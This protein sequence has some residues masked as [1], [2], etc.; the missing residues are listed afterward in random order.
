MRNILRLIVASILLACVNAGCAHTV[1]RPDAVIDDTECRVGIEFVGKAYTIGVCIRFVLYGTEYTHIVQEIT[2]DSGEVLVE[3]FRDDGFLWD[4]HSWI[5]R[6]HS[7]SMIVYAANCIGVDEWSGFGH[8]P[9]NGQGLYTT[10]GS[11]FNK[12][13]QERYETRGY[14]RNR[15]T[16]EYE[17]SIADDGT[18]ITVIINGETY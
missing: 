1:H 3:C 16:N 11:N 4:T 8:L 12:D 10:V 7:R 15:A 5:D 13:Y 14:I 2:L 17:W 9:D 6:P 18:H